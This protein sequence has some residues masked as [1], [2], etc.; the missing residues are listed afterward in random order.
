MGSPF[1]LDNNNDK[2]TDLLMKNFSP[3]QRT[4]Q[5]QVRERKERK[6]PAHR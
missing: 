4:S 3:N 1:P 2:K 5:L 6:S